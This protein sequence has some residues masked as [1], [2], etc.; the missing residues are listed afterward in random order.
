VKYVRTWRKTRWKKFFKAPIIVSLVFSLAKAVG[1]KSEKLFFCL[2]VIVFTCVDVQS[3]PLSILWQQCYGGSADDF[4]VS[5]LPSNNGFMLLGQTSSNDVQ[6]NGNHGEEDFWLVNIDSSGNFLNSKCYGGS[7]FD[8]PSQMISCPGG[9][10]ALFG[11]T[12]SVNGTVTGNHGGIDYWIIRVDDDGNFLWQKCLGGS[13]MD[14]GRRISVTYDSGFV[15][16][17]WSNSQDGDVTGNHGAFDF[18][19]VK[20]D[21]NGN[22][23]WE[24]SLGGSSQDDGLC[25]TATS[26]KGV[27]VGGWTGSADGDVQCL[28]HSEIDAWVLKLDSTGSIEWQKCYGGSLTDCITSIVQLDDGSY[29]YA[30]TTQSNDGDVSGNHGGYDYWVIK[31]D[32]WGNLIWQKCYGGGNDETP[33]FIKRLSDGNFIIGG[34]TYSNDG[35]VTNNHSFQD[36]K[37]MWLIKISPE[38]NLI[39]QQCFGGTDNETMHDVVELSGQ[40]LFAIGGSYTMNN[41]GNVQC[42]HHGPGTDDMWLL[43]V[44]DSTMVGVN[45]HPDL[46]DGLKV[47]PNPAGDFVKFSCKTK[48]NITEIRIQ[49]IDQLGQVFKVLNMPATANEMTW[50]TSKVQS[51]VY[52]FFYYV[53]NIKRIGKIVVI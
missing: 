44:Y 27:I 40:R 38:G 13:W 50:D 8:A 28:H 36:Y 52:Y 48:D 43:M 14:I 46:S 42:T 34:D 22:V 16:I 12:P 6:V 32:H 18:W 25:V 11:S 15:C 30:G 26:D 9:G 1:P 19:A 47:Y 49:I 53:A 45:E 4:G 41:T 37:D 21:K 29:M 23:K 5:V 39:W 24:K 33:Y 17:G 10:F 3:Q 20:L 7:D 31:T 35:D 2:I 51:G